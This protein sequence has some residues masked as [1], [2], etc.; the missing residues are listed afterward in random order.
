TRPQILD[1]QPALGREH[2]RPAENLDS[3]P[4]MRSAQG[5]LGQATSSRGPRTGVCQTSLL[6]AGAVHG[7]ALPCGGSRGPS[8]EDREAILTHMRSEQTNVSHIEV[9]RPPEIRVAVVVDDPGEPRARA[10]RKQERA[11]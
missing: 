2:S 5:T 11:N 3:R 7:R 1:S 9:G 10:G 6:L 4:P 8:D